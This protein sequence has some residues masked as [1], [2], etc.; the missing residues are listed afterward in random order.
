[1]WIYEHK[2][3]PEFTFDLEK[4]TSKLAKIRYKQGMLI[5]KME[6]LGFDL[7]QQASL[8]VITQDVIKSSAIEAENLDYH[9][10]RSS[11]ARRLGLDIAGLVSS[12][13][14][15]DGVVEMLIDA[16]HNFQHPLTEER[17][18]G[19]HAALFPTGYSGLKK[20]AVAQYRLAETEPMQVVSGAI[21]REKMHYQAPHADKLKTEMNAFLK[22]FEQSNSIDMVLKAGIA[23]L[24]FISI[25]PFEDGNGR[26]AR[27]IADMALARADN[28]SE[29]F[30]SMSK[31][32]ESEK[33]DYYF[34]L[35]W[36]QKSTTDVTHWL[37][38]FLSCLER[39]VDNADEIIGKVLYKAKVWNIVNQNLI[40]D[41]QRKV[42]NLMLEDDCEGHMNT[43]KYAKLAKCS[44]DTALRDI[45]ELKANGIFLRNP[46][47]GRSTSYRLI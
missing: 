11:V 29:R 15:V 14:S 21:G 42:I 41:R 3:W 20:I 19:W 9:E 7:R 12:S 43:S 40:N 34:Q 37:E 25:H 33:D 4:L 1:M 13:K 32:I 10:V 23:H 24:W 26:I 8:Q 44:T 31:Q 18:Y 35:E 27:A 47:G 36:Q 28:M 17:L 30:Y 38:W 2:T 6:G 22:W 39:A 5:G 16:T 46:G 45:Q